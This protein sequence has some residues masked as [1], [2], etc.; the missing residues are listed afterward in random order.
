[1]QRTA[2]VT[3]A[4]SGIGAVTA[5]KLA[6]AGYH[7]VL[8]ARRADRMTEIVAKIRGA[9][10]QADAHQLD[11]PDRAQVDALASSL[12]DCHV[13]FSNAG[14]AIGA[15]QVADSSPDD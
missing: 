8:A 13:L 9:G 4:S 7:V 14:G 15:D 1:M 3:G 5:G 10:G 6:E 2:V 11:V 12:D